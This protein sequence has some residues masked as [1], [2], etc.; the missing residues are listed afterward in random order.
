MLKTERQVMCI[1]R[2]QR[3]HLEVLLAK[4][5]DAGIGAQNNGGVRQRPLYNRCP[6]PLKPKDGLIQSLL[7]LADGGC[8][9][10]WPF[11]R[12]RCWEGLCSGHSC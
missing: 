5:H 1:C 8:D 7:L 11:S 4:E 6:G 9:D 3:R 10:E 2:C 12:L